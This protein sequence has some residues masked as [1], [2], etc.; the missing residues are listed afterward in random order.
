MNRIDLFWK[1]HEKYHD[2]GF[3]SPQFKDLITHMLQ[4]KPFLRPGMV[5]LIGHEW[6]TSGQIATQDQAFGEMAKRC[7]I[8]K[9]QKQ[10]AQNNAPAQARQT[11]RG[12]PNSTRLMK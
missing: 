7:M 2:Q 3:F 10:M 9:A 5:D 8:N 6:L 12:N 11:K 4:V 1:K